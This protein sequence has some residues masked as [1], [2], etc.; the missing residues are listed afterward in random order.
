MRPKKT[1]WVKCSTSER[2]FKPLTKAEK[3][4]KVV[5]IDFG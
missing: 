2:I 5:G 4:T 3:I 1:R